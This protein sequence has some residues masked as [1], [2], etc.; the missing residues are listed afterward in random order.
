MASQG[1]LQGSL[2]HGL[3]HPLHTCQSSAASRGP[4]GHRWLAGGTD[5]VAKVGSLHEEG[6]LKRPFFFKF[7]FY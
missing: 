6:P 7:I 2:G 1:P 3:S 4:Y 5:F